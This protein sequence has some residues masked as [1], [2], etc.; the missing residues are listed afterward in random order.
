[1]LGAL[2]PKH[3]EAAGYHAKAYTPTPHPS[4]LS[5]KEIIPKILQATANFE[6]R[7]PDLHFPDGAPDTQSGPKGLFKETQTS[8]SILPKA[9]NAK[10]V[11]SH[12]PR[13]H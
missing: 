2:V 1:M 5:F 4:V 11:W 8:R 7:N 12:A 13:Q 9:H 10:E 6:N 3:E